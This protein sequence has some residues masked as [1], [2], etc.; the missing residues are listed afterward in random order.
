[1]I[2]LISCNN[3][4]MNSNKTTSTTTDNQYFNQKPPGLIPE[5]F[6]PGI[7]STHNWEVGGVF[8]PD[9]EEFYF[10]REIGENEEEKA[11][12]FMVYQLINNEWRASIISDRV[13]QPFISPDGKTMHL[14][15]RYKERLENG[16]WSAIKNLDS[17]LYKIPIMRLT[18]SANGTF[19]FDAMGEGVLRFSRIVNGE[20]ENPKLF[21]EDINSGS[22][23]AHP[24][25]A[26]DES[27]ILWDSRRESGYGKADIYV[28][29]RQEDGSWGKS[30]NLG[31]SINTTAS[32]NGAR[33]TPDGKYLFFNR[34]V[35]K[36]KPTDKYED[37]NMF[38]VDAKILDT[39][40]EKE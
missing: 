34:T 36:V 9:L 4:N 19:V 30:I 2:V 24:F 15:R 25:I 28:S 27:Y 17:S 35:G 23:N 7:V 21:S 18:T 13:G 40:K 8:T 20:R 12:K 16:D 37:V 39:L 3:Q 14:G 22:A 26:P 32:E 5:P 33:V 6:A 10:I 1:M 31:E 29:F 38:W 11:M